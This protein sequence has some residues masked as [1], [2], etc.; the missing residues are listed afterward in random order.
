[1]IPRL[2]AIKI[3]RSLAVGLLLL[4]FW[5]ESAAAQPVTVSTV[6]TSMLATLCQ[7]SRAALDADFCTGYIAGTFDQLSANRVICPGVGVT[8]EQFLAVGRRYIET[9]PEIWDRHPSTVLETAFRAAFAC[10]G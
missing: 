9:H 2:R 8:T 10:P 5:G 4:P 3:R 6:T 7:R 1:M